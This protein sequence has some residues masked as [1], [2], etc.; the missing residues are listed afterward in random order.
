M[1]DAINRLARHDALQLGHYNAGLSDDAVRQRY[2]VTHIA[3]LASNENPL[4]MSP[5]AENALH[6]SVAL[7]A[8]YPDAASRQ[9]RAA[10]ALRT[11]LTPEQVVIGNGSENLLE[12]LCLAFLNPGDRVVTLLPSFGLHQLYPQMMGAE[13]T[14]V[15]VNAEMEYDLDAWAQA[16]RQPAK[17]VVFSNPANPV[18]CMLGRDAFTRLIAMTPR[19][20]LLVIDEAYY[21]YCVADPD[22]PDSLALL[23]EQERPW[24]VLRTF[25]KAYGLAGLRVGYGLACHAELVALLDRVRTPFNI[26]RAA[27]AAA[28][29]ALDDDAHMA[30][31]VEYVT[32]QRDRLAEQL[33]AMGWFVAPSQAN[34]LFFNARQESAVLAQR[35]LREGVIIKPW[36][37]TGYTQ[38]CRVSI[39]SEEA[40]QQFIT[41]LARV[42]A[43]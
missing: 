35:L 39:G 32:Q 10:I 21:E 4:G 29:A 34:F 6:A 38:W 17:M 20:C 16:L 24:I 23:H 9:L 40:N 2:A 22:Y 5:Q 43:A 37:E 26:N 12:M 14:L 42:T 33:R 13:V 3:R 15:P 8:L 1:K 36:L 31:S 18:G 25:S 19:D 30:R 7:S 11:G 28:L 41:A 27:Q